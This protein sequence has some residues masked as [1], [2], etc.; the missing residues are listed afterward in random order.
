M[1]KVS[2]ILTRRAVV[3]VSRLVICETGGALPV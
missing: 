1:R 3:V 2:L